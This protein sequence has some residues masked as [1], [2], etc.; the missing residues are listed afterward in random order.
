MN[1]TRILQAIFSV[2]CATVFFAC[3][4]KAA[5]PTE[6]DNTLAKEENFS[7]VSCSSSDITSP[8]SSTTDSFSSSSSESSNSN[9]TTN[10]KVFTPNSD[11]IDSLIFYLDGWDITVS[12]W[13]GLF[14]CYDSIK[15]AQ[16]I[17]NTITLGKFISGRTEKLMSTGLT[18]EQASSTAQQE[19]F[20][21]LGI[22]TLLREQP[23]Q[24]KFVNNLLN[25]IF[26]GTT[27]SEFYEE[28]E[29]TFTET[30]TLSKEHLC[31]ITDYAGTPEDKLPMTGFTG[32]GFPGHVLYEYT[33]YNSMKCNGTLL[34]P[35]RIV[36]IINTKCYDMPK[37]D[38]TNIGTIVKA[39]YN[40]AEKIFTCRATGWDGANTM[41]IM[42]FGIEC[43]KEGKNV[44]YGGKPINKSFICSL[45]SGWYV[46][47]TIDAETFDVPCDKHGKLY[48]S[49][50]NP[51]K[52]YVCRKEHFCR[53]Y[54]F[55]YADALCMDE[56]WDYATPNDIEMSKEECD[57]E[58]KTYQSPSDT[59]L[60]Y[61]CHEDKWKEFYNMPCDTDNKRVKVRNNSVWT[62]FT[63]YICYDKTWRPTYEWHTD[64]PAEYYFNPEINYGSFMD[65]RDN[66]VYHT[67]E[68]KGRTWIA[69]NM[70]YAGFADSVLKK[71][72]RCLDDSCKNVG[73][74]YSM[75]VADKVC[76]DGWNLPDSSDILTLGTK[77][78][79]TEHLISQLGGT[80]SNYSAPD[81]Y[82]LS[83]I[84][85][86]QIFD[87]NPPYLNWQ[88][89]EAL[90]WMNE[91]NTEGARLVVIVDY[92]KVEFDGY[93]PNPKTYSNATPNTKPAAFLTVRCVKK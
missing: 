40:S 69:E 42:T 82:G 60:Y 85:S 53:H 16:A 62:G 9:P 11:I 39:K 91:T 25:Y 24:R 80:G 75:H 20:A 35:S 3:S 71:E 70:K 31:N 57:S 34:I 79:E 56:G 90:F 30:G 52:T 47:E 28:V 12:G 22:D 68:F 38:S 23:E 74:Y 4:E 36:E 58:G 2:A 10:S 51:T 76:P 87:T 7:N 49:T 59:N 55:Y 13:K 88:G 63:E 1:I 6:C 19:L 78:I 72:T 64:Y 26:G 86:G 77:Q 17:E 41:E 50:S 8:G 18:Q 66:Y 93:Y 21:A 81:T 92:Y 43:D 54:D 44:F 33:M 14:D 83:F 61:V 5:D 84:L 46:A 37:C 89:Y 67:V 32:S 27:Q 29:Q 48:T 15:V 73:R 65:P 45:D